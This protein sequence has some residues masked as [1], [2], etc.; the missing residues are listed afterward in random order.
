M[1]MKELNKALSDD[2][3]IAIEVLKNA[4]WK[5]FTDISV[6]KAGPLGER[7]P[8]FTE[9]GDF[10]VGILRKEFGEKTARRTKKKAVKK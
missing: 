1:E 10:K 5:I 7:F 4:G 3:L 2:E 9:G 8:L 6:E